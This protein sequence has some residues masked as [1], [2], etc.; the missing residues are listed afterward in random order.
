M[1]RWD[2]QMRLERW[3]GEKI[4]KQMILLQIYMNRFQIREFICIDRVNGD[5]NQKVSFKRH[6]IIN[7]LMQSLTQD[8]NTL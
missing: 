6:K 8:I 3:I 5:K 4:H 7:N 2:N 1:D